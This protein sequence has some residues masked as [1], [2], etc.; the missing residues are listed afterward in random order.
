[1]I[2]L[3]FVSACFV[4]L[5]ALRRFQ[6]L[7]LLGGYALVIHRV[8]TEDLAGASSGIFLLL[9]MR[10]IILALLFIYL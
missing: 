9:H 10:P 6:Q 2:R 3:N 5:K 1:M 4:S 7:A 8:W